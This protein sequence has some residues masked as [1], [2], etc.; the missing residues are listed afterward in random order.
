MNQTI[1]YTQ[2]DTQ[3]PIEVNLPRSKSL[4]H[5]HLFLQYLHNGNS[6][7][8]GI[9]NSRDTQIFVNAIN[10]KNAVVDFLD[11]GTPS[12]FALVYFSVTNQAK[13][14]TGNQSLKNR[15]I[16]DLVNTLC[17]QG[18]QIEYLDKTGYFPVIIHRGITKTKTV[19]EITTQESSQFVSALM[20]GATAF[21]P[22]PKILVK[23]L[24]H[25]WSYINL[26]ADV[27]KAWGFPV[28][29]N[30]HEIS[31]GGSLRTPES[32]DVEIDWGSASFVYLLA[33]F[34]KKSFRII[35]ANRKS[36]QADYQAVTAF[37]SLG[38]IT[39]YV[40]NDA[41]ITYQQVKNLPAEFEGS[42]C[43][44]LIPALASAYAYLQKD[45]TFKG[46]QKLAVKESNRLE[47]IEFHLSQLGFSWQ[48]S[49][50]KYVLT[51][52]SNIYPQQF[53]IHTHHDHRIAM[54]F[55]PW[56]SIINSVY[57][58]DTTCTEK[59]FPEYWELLKMCNFEL[60]PNNQPS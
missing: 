52:N 18:A 30:N 55:A 51:N 10:D 49:S 38:V 2:I 44:D 47:R 25:S 23:G 4:S 8:R 3:S 22:I 1:K 41:I 33:I 42:N 26:S 58:D 6:E 24:T 46:I 14:L 11:A 12:R 19:W 21:K 53:N 48:E 31:I 40:N 60:L 43:I 5:R 9:S 37:G 35:G 15:S 13:T 16:S 34:T 36:T 56:A 17:Q 7:I 39:Q 50:G 20:L 57:I 59:S 28:N 29:I 45:I 32:I 27:L 54:A